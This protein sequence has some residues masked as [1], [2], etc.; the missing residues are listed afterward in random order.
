MSVI[1][2]E[3]QFRFFNIFN[4]AYLYQNDGFGIIHLLKR[5][6]N[7]SYSDIAR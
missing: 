2:S 5:S 3:N 1:S 7:W 6:N 4:E